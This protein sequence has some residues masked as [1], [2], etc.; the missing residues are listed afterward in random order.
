ML[1]EVHHDCSR[2]ADASDYL[3]TPATI[4]HWHRQ[5]IAHR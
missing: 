1:A 3:L 5:L 4:L 2:S